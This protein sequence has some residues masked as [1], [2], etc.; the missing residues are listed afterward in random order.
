MNEAPEAPDQRDGCLGCGE[1]EGRGRRPGPIFSLGFEF[2]N[3]AERCERSE[4]R[5]E[6][7]TRMTEGTEDKDGHPCCWGGVSRVTKEEESVP[8]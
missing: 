5:E 1:G 3:K 2:V 7:R 6:Y 4:R 8:F